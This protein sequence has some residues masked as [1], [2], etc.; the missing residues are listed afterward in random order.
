[1]KYLI[2][3]I[4]GFMGTHL[5]NTLIANEHFVVGLGQR[6]KCHIDGIGQYYSGDI[7]NKDI[8]EE[9]MNEVEIV[10]HL[11]AL[12]EH[13]DLVD[14]QFKALE[15]N[16]LGT[17]NVLD[18]FCNAKQTQKF[19]YSSSGKVYGNFK[20]LPITENE[21]PTP[22]NILGKSK[23][24]TEQLI[25]F[26]SNQNK[27][28]IICRIFNVYGHYQKPNFLI[29]TILNQ[30]DFK[31]KQDSIE[32]TLGDI[33]SKRDYIYIDDVI[34]ALITCAEKDTPNQLSIYNI[35]TNRGTSA[36][37]IVNQLADIIKC[38][39]KIK[40]D[41]TLFRLDEKNIEYGSYDKIYNELGWKPVIPLEEGF[42]RII[43]RLMLD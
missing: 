13:K 6:N 12:T 36:L 26:Y 9:A 17:K 40:T 5:A 4:N 29:P 30:I 23:L 10:V 20:S 39:I 33:H 14:N 27:Q 32:I 38:P 35:G 31:N 41:K 37:E 42:R 19:I 21:Y 2:T 11:A 43:D 1:M 22:L 8:V 28:L 18:V 25:D 15:V 24:I 7:L 34:Q 16:F 3:G